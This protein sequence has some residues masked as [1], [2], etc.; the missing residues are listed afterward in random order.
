MKR[1]TYT[2][3]L[4]AATRATGTSVNEAGKWR[5]MSG[6][7]LRTFAI[8]DHQAAMMRCCTERDFARDF[9]ARCEKGSDKTSASHLRE[10]DRFIEVRIRHHGV[11]GAKRFDV[12]R[13]ESI[14]R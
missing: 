5:A 11:N 9:V 8:D 4:F 2:A 3:R 1:A 7:S 12:V 6:G 10:L 14:E 13:P